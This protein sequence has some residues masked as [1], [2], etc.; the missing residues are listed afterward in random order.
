M[1][2][3]RLQILPRIRLVRPKRL[4]QEKC[5]MEETELRMLMMRRRSM[6]KRTEIWLQRVQVMRRTRNRKRCEK[7]SKAGEA[8]GGRSNGGYGGDGER[9]AFD[10][11]KNK[12]EE[13]YVSAKDTM[14]DQA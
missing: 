2:I 9:D 8:A 12:V 4:Y 10:E 14:T 1:P 3:T 13:A 5:N 7:A 6:R 11:T